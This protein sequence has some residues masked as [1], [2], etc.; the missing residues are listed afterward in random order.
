MAFFVG[1]AKSTFRR[2]DKRTSW[3]YNYGPATLSVLPNGLWDYA[4]PSSS[5]FE[6]AN[7]A[8]YAV[9]KPVTVATGVTTASP[10]ISRSVPAYTIAQQPLLTQAPQITFLPQIRDTEERTAKLDLSYALSDSV[11]FFKR[12][13]SG[14]NLRDSAGNNWGNGGY[15]VQAAVGTYNQAGYVA[16]I[17]LP[18]AL[19]RGSF[20]G[21]TNTPGSLA[22]GGAACNYGFVPANSPGGVRSGQTTMTQS[23]FQDSITQAMTQPANS[24]NFNGA[25]D[26]PAKRAIW[27]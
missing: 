25:R 24:I 5:T 9:A 26:R 16:P 15:T 17:V 23:A 3:A 6:Q 12:V 4:F 19:I 8:L 14:F 20:V 11:P 7:A 10:N 21:C 1:D 18:G 13:K 22:P 2:G 27:A